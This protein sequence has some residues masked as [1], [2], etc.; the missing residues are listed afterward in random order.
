MT[1]SL[2]LAFLT[3]ASIGDA[4]LEGVRGTDGV[5]VVAVGSRE[6]GRAEAYARS[7]GIERAHGSYDAVLADAE[8]DAVYIALPC[9]LHAEWAV[10]ALEA[11]KHVLCEKPFSREPA[12]VERAFDAAEHAGLVLMEGFMYRHQPQVKRLKELVEAGAIGAPRVVRSQF[13]FTLDR[14]DDVRWSRELGGG[15]L[16]DVGSY[17]VNVSRL[18][19]GEPDV[20]Y[21]EQVL[22]GPDGVDVRFVATLRF[23]GDVLGHF[24][25]GFDLPIRHEVEV[26]GSDGR[27]R[28]SPAFMS[29]EGV[30]ELT[31][32]G[33]APERVDLP[34][35]NRFHLEVENFMRA[36]RGEEPPLLDCR[37]TVGQA[38]VLDALLRS[39]ENGTP[40]RP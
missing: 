10:R 5:D 1:D 19:A 3:T 24:D 2:R 40:V 28:L 17:C 18:V 22:A 38:R 11:G 37:E 36:I 15:S 31:R 8:V 4:L 25:C 34:A 23:P 16:L 39:A 14:P 20:V 26:V 12:D 9:A 6:L 30:L 29:D 35:T 13:S 27:L 7:R 33:G 21:A 32:G